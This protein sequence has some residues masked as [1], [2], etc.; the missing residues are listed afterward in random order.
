MAGAAKTAKTVVEKAKR[1]TKAKEHPCIKMTNDVLAPQ[2]ERLK[3]ALSLVGAPARIYVATEKK[4]DARGNPRMLAAT[5][6]PFCG[7][8]MA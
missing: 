2:G 1:R 7:K 3:F 4:G 5:Y 6:C 8:K